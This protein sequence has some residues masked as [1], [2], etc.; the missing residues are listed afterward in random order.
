[1]KKTL[2]ALALAALPVASMAD[3][4]LYGQVK[5]GVETVFAKK[6]GGQK[7]K[8]DKTTTQIVDYGSR[9][10]FKGHEHLNGDL[11]AIW[12]VEQKVSIG[13]DARAKMT[14][15]TRTSQYGFSTRDSFVGLQ[16]GFGT[17]KAGYLQT[18][19]SDLNGKLDQW[20]YS[21]DE[22]GLAHF[23]R[24]TDASRRATA[25][26]YTTPDMGGFNATAYVS[27]SDNNHH[28][29]DFGGKLHDNA[30]YGVGL[31]YA[32]PNGGFFA[33]LAGTYV[34]NGPANANP[35]KS[36]SY[37]AL[38]QVGYETDKVLVGAAYQRASAVDA[39]Y[40]IV[41]E[42]A[43]SG[44]YQVDDALRLKATAA[45]GWGINEHGGQTKAFGNGKYYQGLVGADYALSKRTVL[46][47]QAG[48]IQFG[49]KDEKTSGGIVGVGMSHK[50]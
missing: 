32:Q 6:D 8:K 50:F 29:G 11:K 26:S 28:S 48:Y 31:S 15:G 3:V 10:G 23:T 34:K 44:A 22:A 30:I 41:N 47:A 16:G 43:L 13:G 38:A 21:N 7:E 36:K 14:D 4:I 19:V 45:Y 5:G 2:I 18:P 17:V 33:D 27:P 37:Q 49:K 40:D 35:R 9:I 12:Q 24:D 25:I 42:A 20:E 1:M 39:D 46:N